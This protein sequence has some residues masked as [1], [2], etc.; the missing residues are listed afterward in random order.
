MTPDH[1]R[2]VEEFLRT[3]NKALAY[4]NAY[5]EPKKSRKVILT[6]AK[7]LLNRAEIRREIR[8]R[9]DAAGVTESAIVDKLWEIANE[10]EGKYSKDGDRLELSSHRNAVAALSKLADI[11][12]MVKKDGGN[13]NNFTQFNVAMAKVYSPEREKELLKQIDGKI[14]WENPDTKN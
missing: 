7:R 10:K 2:F 4:E 1:F 14:I 11:R 5:P 13:S 9:V 6:N 8:A 3:G 12:G